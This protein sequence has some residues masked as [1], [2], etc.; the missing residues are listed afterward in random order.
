MEVSQQIPL[1]PREILRN[2]FENLYSK[3]LE[4]LE[5]TEKNFTYVIFQN[6]M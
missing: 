1:K 6:W 3:I 4:N 2:S 5:E